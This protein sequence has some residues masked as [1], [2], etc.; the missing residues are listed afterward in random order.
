M[1]YS[2]T[3][4]SAFLLTILLL[5]WHRMW[6]SLDLPC[7]AAWR[8]NDPFQT[9]EFP[10]ARVCPS[11]HSAEFDCPHE[12]PAGYNKWITTANGAA[13]SNLRRRQFIISNQ[14]HIPG[15]WL[16]RNLCTIGKWTLCR[17]EEMKM[18]C[19]GERKQ[20]ME[21]GCRGRESKE[22]EM[23]AEFPFNH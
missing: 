16:I 21:I 17:R 18:R 7:G 5:Y 9:S 11:N 15:A 8:P 22:R 6:V 13:S 1:I 23:I 20:E 19:E 12:T 10:G 2:S 3:S 14:T 4:T